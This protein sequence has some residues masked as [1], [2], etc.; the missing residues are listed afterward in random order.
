MIGPTG[1]RAYSRDV[2][3]AEVAAAAANRPEQ[4]G[5]LVG[6]GANDPAVGRDQIGAQ[7]V[8]E[9]ET[10]LRHQPAD[11]AAERQARDPGAADNPARRREA[12]HLGLAIELF[13]QGATLGPDGAA[14]RVD[15]DPLHRRQVDQQA[16]IESGVPGDVVAAAA[17]RDRQVKRP[18]QCHRVDD[19][20]DAVTARD[21][22]RTPVDQAVVNPPQPVV[23]RIGGLQ[24]L[25][26]E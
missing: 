1:W 20:S 8:V 9:R 11:A 18:C 15:V 19:I 5:V 24:E 21:R 12:V 26:G 2:G 6:A 10:V 25:S 4:I 3:D 23:C 7:Q 22:G 14:P 16:A 17:H 13:P